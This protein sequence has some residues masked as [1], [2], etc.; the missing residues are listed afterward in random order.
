MRCT[1]VNAKNAKASLF[2]LGI[3]MTSC[4]RHAEDKFFGPKCETGIIVSLQQ[5]D[6]FGR[7]LSLVRLPHGQFRPATVTG[8]PSVGQKVQVCQ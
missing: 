5:P 8:W 2:I 7:A 1:M 6:G 4:A 3:V